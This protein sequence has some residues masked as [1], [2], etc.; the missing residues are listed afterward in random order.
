[1]SVT[2]RQ[3]LGFAFWLVLALASLAAAALLII[4]VGTVTP[5]WVAVPLGIALVVLGFA[6]MIF[7]MGKAMDSGSDY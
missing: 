2:F 3:A 4:L 1:M 7:L 5:W 6:T